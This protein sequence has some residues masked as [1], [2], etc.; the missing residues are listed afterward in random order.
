M[1][2][3]IVPEGGGVS[4][5]GLAAL[6]YSGVHFLSEMGPSRDFFDD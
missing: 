6:I 1:N 3:D 4:I 2:R 5:I